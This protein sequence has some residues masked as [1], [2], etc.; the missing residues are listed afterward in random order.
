MPDVNPIPPGFEGATPYLTVD[1]GAA[2]IDFYVA[3]F[4]AVETMRL[5]DPSGRIGHA[6]IKIGG[7]TIMLS[8]E[9]PDMGIVSPKTLGGASSG[10]LVY[11]EDVD[12][13]FARAV[14]AGAEVVQPV[15]DQFYGDRSGQVRDP[16]GQKWSIATHIE[17]VSEEE[18]AARAAA[19]FE[20][21]DASS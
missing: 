5:P 17:D 10:T 3:A 6:E 16:F 11:V 7:A 12:A 1:D 21:A 19:F 4:G 15:T 9:F 20:Q 8:D 14:A 13:V 2:A 18:M